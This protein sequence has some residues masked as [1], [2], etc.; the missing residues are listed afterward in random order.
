[1]KKCVMIVLL[2]A[3]CMT[4]C[5]WRDGAS[6]TASSL[7]SAAFSMVGY[8]MQYD[9]AAGFWDEKLG[10][11]KGLPPRDHVVMTG[12]ENNETRGQ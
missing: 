1:M 7:T 11:N 9:E 3:L 8:E 5:S 10:A 4:G 12:A 2:A 6:F